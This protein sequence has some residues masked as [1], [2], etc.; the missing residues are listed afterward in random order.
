MKILGVSSS[1]QTR[2]WHSC[3]SPEAEALGPKNSSHSQGNPDFPGNGW[4]KPSKGW[5]SIQFTRAI[6]FHSIPLEM[7]RCLKWNAQNWRMWKVMMAM[8]CSKS[9]TKWNPFFES[10]D[11]GFCRYCTALPWTR[12]ATMACHD[13]PSD[14]PRWL[15]EASREAEKLRGW[16]SSQAAIHL[17]VVIQ[18]FEDFLQ[19][20]NIW[21]HD[22]QSLADWLWHKFNLLWKLK[23]IA[24]APRW[25]GELVARNQH[26][27]SEKRPMKRPMKPMKLPRDVK[28]NGCLKLWRANWNASGKPQWP[29]RIECRTADCRR[30]QMEQWETS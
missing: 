17:H 9:G 24:G 11:M 23:A 10:S 22:W 29:Y 8:P 3:G 16:G 4:Y 27:A 26:L 14:V 30:K 25:S 13:K 28:S 6:T 15:S 7:N 2:P 19:S 18:V 20:L 21:K 5:L 12:S 1:F